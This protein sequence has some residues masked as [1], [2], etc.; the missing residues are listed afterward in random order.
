[1]KGLLFLIAALAV[2]TSTTLAIS[3]YT[4][5]IKISEEESFR[6]RDSFKEK[7]NAGRYMNLRYKQ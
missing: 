7:G 6:L 3:H 5:P 2:L 1:M 4:A